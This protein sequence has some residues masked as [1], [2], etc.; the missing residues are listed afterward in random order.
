[1]HADGDV[2]AYSTTVSDR[3]LKENITTIESATETV[4]Q[5]RG[6][7]YDWK[8]GSGTR[9]GQTEIGLIAQEVEEVL[10]FIVREK[11]LMRGEEVKTVD[12]EKLVGLL[13][14]SNKELSSRI[15]ELEKR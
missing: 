11:T 7:Q 4:K 1:M 14:E 12:Y 3:R 2:I 13:I 5:L 8:A 10:P 9:E 6:V 15:H